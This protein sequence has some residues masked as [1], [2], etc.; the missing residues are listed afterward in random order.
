MLETLNRETASFT[1]LFEAL[2]RDV[3]P[4]LPRVQH[5][6]GSPR[7][8][9]RTPTVTAR[10]LILPPSERGLVR[11]SRWTAERSDYVPASRLRLT[12]RGR[13]SLLISSIV[14]LFTAF[15]VGQVMSNAA[16]SGP[17]THTT[18]TIVVAPGDTA[19]SIAREAM[20]TLDGRDA[21]DRLLALNHSNGN[22]RAGQTLTVPGP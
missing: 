15:S 17:A 4:A 2:Q 10:P 1:P 6:P 9:L 18:H 19:W 20:P 21:V 16:G 22:I 12:R 11:Q 3:V 8:A 5:R 14:L 13:L 7:A